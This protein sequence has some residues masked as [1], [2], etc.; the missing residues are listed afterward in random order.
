MPEWLKDTIFYE[1]S[2]EEDENDM[3][4]LA[5]GK[6]TGSWKEREA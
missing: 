2:P 6:I 1:I 4:Y 5:I 3:A